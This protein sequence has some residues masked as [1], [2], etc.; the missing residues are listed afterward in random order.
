MRRPEPLEDRL[1]RFI[2]PDGNGCW[3]WT[4]PSRRGSPMLKVDGERRCVRPMLYAMQHGSRPSSDMV[5]R[6]QIKM[7]C[8]VEACVCPDHMAVASDQDRLLTAIK[9]EIWREVA[10]S[11]HLRWML[12][13]EKLEAEARRRL[14]RRL[15]AQEPLPPEAQ[16]IIDQIRRRSHARHIASSGSSEGYTT[17]QDTMVT[18][19]V[20]NAVPSTTDEPEQG[21]VRQ[22]GILHPGSA[23]P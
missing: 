3:I 17:D 9:Q 16:A 20:A 6:P 23:A 14:E 18:S 19:G 4:G 22:I 10:G 11:T 13:P 8:G 5:A 12:R 15:A 21:P 7:A 2:D 1:C